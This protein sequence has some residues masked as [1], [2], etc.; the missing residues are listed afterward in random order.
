MGH[1]KS[2][3]YAV[4]FP[5]WWLGNNKNKRIQILSNTDDNAMKRVKTI[6]AYIES[7]QTYRDIFPEIIPD[8]EA[9]WTDHDIHV[10]RDYPQV[11]PSISAYGILSSGTGSRC[12]YQVLDDPVDEDNSV[13]QPAKKKQIINKYF[14]SWFTRIQRP[15]FKKGF[16]GCIGTRYAEDDLISVL[17]RRNIFRVLVQGVNPKMNSIISITKKYDQKKKTNT[18]VKNETLPLWSKYDGRELVL[19]RTTMGNRTFLK[20]MANIIDG[21]SEGILADWE[22]CKLELTVDEVRNRTVMHW[23]GVD[24]SSNK[25]PGNVCVTVGITPE[26]KR[27][28]VDI[29]R[30]KTSAQIIS[31]LDVVEERF[32]PLEYVLEDVGVQSTL[33]G[34][35][36]LFGSTNPMLHK[37]S[38]K[39]STVC[40]DQKMKF[41]VFA[42]IPS[43]NAQFANFGWIFPYREISNHEDTCECEWCTLYED[44]KNY[45]TAGRNYD[46]LLSLFFASMKSMVTP[47][48][49]D[50]QKHDVRVFTGIRRKEF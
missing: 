18:I 8:K 16:A 24:F 47:M 19:N 12:D 6:K 33:I 1:G 26:G 2:V 44:L 48:R 31:M 23:S 39:L 17:E 34:F 37:W 46:I 32:H 3:N 35:I 4:G 28:P 10:V 5:L 15:L 40:T 49:L 13:R 25:R 30:V 50:Y 20:T 9:G 42:G 36:Q 41:D 45:P 38:T 22:K 43:L 14:T 29:Q 27:I 11:D 7:S 21:S